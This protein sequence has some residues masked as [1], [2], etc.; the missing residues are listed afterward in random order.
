MK[1]IEFEVIGTLVIL[2]FWLAMFYA[3]IYLAAGMVAR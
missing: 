2:G 1:R 3:A